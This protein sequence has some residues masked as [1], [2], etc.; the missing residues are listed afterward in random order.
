M[1]YG[2]AI[3]P[4]LK[5]RLSLTNVMGTVHDHRQSE[6]PSPEGEGWQRDMGCVHVSVNRWMRGKRCQKHKWEGFI[7]ASRKD[8]FFPSEMAGDEWG[9]TQG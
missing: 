9:R 4:L 7:L 3:K 6:R 5:F 8:F 2:Y 1:E